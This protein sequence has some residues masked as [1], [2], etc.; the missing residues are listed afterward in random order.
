MHI[1]DPSYDMSFHTEDGYTR[2]E[3][4]LNIG[5]SRD[6]VKSLWKQKDE[7]YGVNQ[8]AKIRLLWPILTHW[9]GKW[10]LSYVDYVCVNTQKCGFGVSVSVRAKRS[11]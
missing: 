6:L 1:H 2:I 5:G 9:R 7:V 11:S 3:L 10:Q 4:D 8:G